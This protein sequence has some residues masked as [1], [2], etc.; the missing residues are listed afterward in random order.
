MRFHSVKVSNYRIHKD[1][2]ADF[3]D[4]LTLIAGPN[5]SGKSTLVEAMH[6]GLYLRPTAAGEA[7]KLMLHSDS[8]AGNPEVEITFSAKGR[9][10]VVRKVFTG[11]NTANIFLQTQGAPPCSGG[12]A[13]ARLADLLGIDSLLAANTIE[14][15]AKKDGHLWV[16]QG[17]AIKAP[18]NFV[19]G[20]NELLKLLHSRGAAGLVMSE[21]DRRTLQRI[22]EAVASSFTDK[23]NKPK[24]NSELGMAENDLRSATQLRSEAEARLAKLATASS[25]V[26]HAEAS[27]ESSTDELAEI[28]RQLAETE[29]KLACIKQKRE[30]LGE[31]DV[32]A[33]EAAGKLQALKQTETELKL[34]RDKLQRLKT[35]LQPLADKVTRL[36]EALASARAAMADASNRREEAAQRA[37]QAREQ[38]ELCQAMLDILEK[39]SEK[40]RLEDL[41]RQ[42]DIKNE[43][44]MKF[45]AEIAGIPDVSTRALKGLRQI[46]G[47]IRDLEIKLSS[48]AV[49]VSLQDGDAALD[50]DALARGETRILTRPSMITV[51]GHTKVLVTP[52]GNE[53]ISQIEDELLQKRD[54]LNQELGI[55]AV[56]TVNDAE[57]AA[58]RL[59]ELKSQLKAEE[60]SLE[61]F[62]STEPRH[63][64][65]LQKTLAELERLKRA[66]Q[67]GGSPELPATTAM[68]AELATDAKADVDAAERAENNAATDWTFAQNREKET[69]ESLESATRDNDS[70]NQEVRALEAVITDTLRRNG[71]DEARAGALAIANS[72]VQE[73]KA[74][75]DDAR[76]QLD[77]L[78]PVAVDA[79]KKRLDASRLVKIRAIENA[80][81]AFNLNRGQLISD[82]VEDP[83]E[84]ASAAR[85]AFDRAFQREKSARE[86]ADAIL[87]L[88]QLAEEEQAAIN[89]EQG[90]PLIEKI[91]RYLSHA[92]GQDS[93]AFLEWKEN[94]AFGGILLDRSRQGK[95]TLP[96][97]WL[98]GGAKEQ[99]GVAVRLALAELIQERENEPQAVILD[100][101]FAY[102]DPVRIR[103]IL[104]MLYEAAARNLQV[105]V[106]TC[107]PAEFAALGATRVDMP[108]P[109]VR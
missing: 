41:Q 83:A 66:W 81:D 70:K 29:R 42:I 76:G 25:A 13:E 60:N 78:A 12:D 56:A 74:K 36:G 28:D 26:Q 45:R 106:L 46:E 44:I 108:T 52:G 7:H 53:T 35:E 47:D 85:A 95:S 59:A 10:H 15:Q 63:E 31:L 5:E 107:N 27:L 68:A 34:N 103:G 16:R 101:S 19:P 69:R 91:N 20:G 105:I 64:A 39:T 79:D 102:S 57:V 92:F 24:K 67:L 51:G 43:K 49:A 2:Q 6:M 3:A 75:F 62:S 50:G 58:N 40:K 97:E 11:K 14:G 9:R 84:K 61:L 30:E 37:R 18:A 77:E 4:G 98:S 90:K 33:K 8:Q 17:D 86:K 89:T 1:L 72:S 73:A 21:T 88:A 82:G 38:R 55:L 104:P 32:R 23:G 99:A 93:L 80:R 109:A 87:F 54:S 22:N 94:N 100:D 96:V 65:K 71:T 48:A